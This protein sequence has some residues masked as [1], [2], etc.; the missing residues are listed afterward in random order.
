VFWRS[1]Y[2]Q[3]ISE[4]IYY[5]LA[6]LSQHFFK[7]FGG[8]IFVDFKFNGRQMTAAEDSVTFLV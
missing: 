6:R 4:R 7:V 3:E 1:Q 5:K 8:G 2:Q